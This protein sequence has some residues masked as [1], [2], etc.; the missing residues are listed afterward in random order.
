MNIQTRKASAAVVQA[1]IKAT[2]A[3]ENHRHSLEMSVAGYEIYMSQQDPA[4]GVK[5]VVP[6]SIKPADVE[7]SGP[8]TGR[9]RKHSSS[10]STAASSAPTSS[11]VVLADSL[12]DPTYSKD[13]INMLVSDIAGVGAPVMIPTDCEFYEKVYNVNNQSAYVYGDDLFHQTMAER[14]FFEGEI[15]VVNWLAVKVMD[16]ESDDQV[17]DGS[18][19]IGDDVY[20]YPPDAGNNPNFPFS[21][22]MCS[23][24]QSKD[25]CNMMLLA[26]SSLLVTKRI[27]KGST[28]LAYWPTSAAASTVSLLA[29][30]TVLRVITSL[31]L[32][33]ELKAL[34]MLKFKQMVGDAVVLAKFPEKE[35][36]EQSALKVMESQ[37]LIENFLLVLSEDPNGFVSRMKTV[38]EW[39]S[40][41]KIARPLSTTAD[42]D[43]TVSSLRNVSSSSSSETQEEVDIVFDAMTLRDCVFMGQCFAMRESFHVGYS[44]VKCCDRVFDLKEMSLAQRYLWFA[45]IQLFCA[46]V[47]DHGMSTPRSINSEYCLVQRQCDFMLSGR[48]HVPYERASEKSFVTFEYQYTDPLPVDFVTRLLD[49]FPASPLLPKGKKRR[50][51]TSGALVSSATEVNGAGETKEEDKGEDSGSEDKDEAEVTGEADHIQPRK[52]S[53]DEMIA[54]KKVKRKEDLQVNLARLNAKLVSVT[55]KWQEGDQK[56][57]FLISHQERIAECTEELNSLTMELEA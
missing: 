33:C 32:S 21:K 6:T 50:V 25:Q 46:E 47:R 40:V 23:E 4:T 24:G 39:D 13:E 45:K 7:T 54:L 5:R 1:A 56:V 37:A 53:K 20:V 14:D 12:I 22:V 31:I 49:Q 55:N 16:S 15:V 18:Y 42:L 41:T 48:F 8:R 11:R 43:A 19:H 57:K 35:T 28:M 3:A 10:S 26:N 2:R 17:P 44:A 30:L 29:D 51:M 9:K 34:K 38:I 27:P 52:L 36:I